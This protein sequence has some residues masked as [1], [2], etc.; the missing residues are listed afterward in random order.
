[1]L[2]RVKSVV[3]RIPWEPTSR[4]SLILGLLGPGALLLLQAHKFENLGVLATVSWLI[5]VWVWGLILLVGGGLKLR[6]RTREFGNFIGFCVYGVFSVC[7]IFTIFSGQKYSPL[8][9]TLP[10]LSM[11][12]AEAMRVALTR[13]VG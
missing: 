6:S 9:L 7:S 13:R 8:I 10:A 11:F 2:R 4:Y 12:Y 5:P 1:M 3:R